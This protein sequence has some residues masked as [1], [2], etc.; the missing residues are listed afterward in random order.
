MGTLT[1][2]MPKRK[3]RGNKQEKK[4]VK[5]NQRVHLAHQ[6]GVAKIQALA[7]DLKIPFRIIKTHKHAVDPRVIYFFTG[8][9][10]S[11]IQPEK[12]VIIQRRISV[13]PIRILQCFVEAGLP[14]L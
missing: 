11:V 13:L 14:L 4:S 5:S 3:S 2:A 6:A 7:E 12:C 9:S 8:R 1:A 10:R